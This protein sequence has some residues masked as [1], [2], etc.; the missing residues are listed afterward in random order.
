MDRGGDRFVESWLHPPSFG[1]K[2]DLQIFDIVV[3][4]TGEDISKLVFLIRVGNDELAAVLV[5]DA[6]GLKIGVELAAPFY[7]EARLQRILGIVKPGMDDL[8][9]ARRGVAGDEVLCLEHDNIAACLR[10]G[11]RYG[12]ADDW[13]GAFLWLR[14][15]GQP[16]VREVATQDDS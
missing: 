13:R 14:P 1:A 5:L 10:A 6:V 2:D 9:V 12:E 8:G 11:T 4:R 16:S 7:A 3:T 15:T